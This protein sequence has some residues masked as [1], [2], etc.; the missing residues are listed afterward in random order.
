[1]ARIPK[2][3]ELTGEGLQGDYPAMSRT[4]SPHHPISAIRPEDLEAFAH[5]VPS[6]GIHLLG[7]LGPQVG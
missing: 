1:M 6:T 7:L 3:F 4:L 5:L 2:R